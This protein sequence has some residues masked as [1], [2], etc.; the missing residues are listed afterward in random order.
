MGYISRNLRMSLVFIGLMS[1][2]VTL[3]DFKISNRII[4]SEIIVDGCYSVS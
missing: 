1:P 3:S 4:D 2:F